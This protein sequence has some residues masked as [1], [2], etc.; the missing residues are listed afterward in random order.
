TRLSIMEL[1]EK[2]LKIPVFEKPIDINSLDQFSE[3]GACGTAAV[4]SPIGSITYKDKVFKFYKDGKEVG[5]ITKKLYELLLSI[6]RG[7]SDIFKEWIYI[8]D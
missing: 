3:V 6:Q 5:P 4:I 7:E 1:C 8:V 2:V